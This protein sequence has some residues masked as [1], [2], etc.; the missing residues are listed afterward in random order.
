MTCHVLRGRDSWPRAPHVT[1]RDSCAE[2]ARLGDGPP[3][4]A[5]R[6]LCVLW[7]P[8]CARCLPRKRCPG[9]AGLPARAA[10]GLRAACCF[11][12]SA[13]R[14]A[15]PLLLPGAHWEGTGCMN[16]ILAAAAALPKGALVLQ[17]MSFAPVVFA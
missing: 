16:R 4:T 5:V 13:A 3:V 15:L 10:A 7:C 9:S 6:G 14:T 2:G 12:V 17:A 8:Q 1:R 11:R